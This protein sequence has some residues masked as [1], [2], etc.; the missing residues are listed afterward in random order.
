MKIVD[1]KTFMAMPKGTV[2]CKFPRFNEATRS[3]SGYMFGIDQPKIK[4]SDAKTDGVDFYAM[5][6][7]S[8]LAPVGSTCDDDFFDILSDMEHNL[9]KEV[10][11]EYSYCRDGLFEPEDKVAFVIFGRAEVELMIKELQHSLEAAYSPARD[12]SPDRGEMNKNDVR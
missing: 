3:Y 9:G 4:M 10:A 8:D 2:F 5:S 1:R 7:G 6:I 12:L 11:F